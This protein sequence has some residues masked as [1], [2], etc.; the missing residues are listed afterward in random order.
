MI[1]KQRNKYLGYEMAHVN[2]SKEKKEMQLV[3]IFHQKT[4]SKLD[5]HNAL[6]LDPKQ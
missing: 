3:A 1:I 5:S 2:C 4:R 6:R